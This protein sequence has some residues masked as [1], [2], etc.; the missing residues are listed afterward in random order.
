MHSEQARGQNAGVAVPLVKVG[1]ACLIKSL[2]GYGCAGLM[3]PTGKRER[4]ALLEAALEAGIRHF[5]VAR[6]YGHGGAEG[7]LG[8]FLHETGLRDSVTITTKFGMEPS[9]LAQT[10]GGKSLMNFARRVATLSPGLRSVLSGI[11]QRGVRANSFNAASA[12]GS[13]DAS[14]KELSTDHVDI[15][16]LHEASADSTEAEG[17]LEFL[18]NF[19]QEGKIRAFGLGTDIHTTLEII[20][21]APAFARVVQIPNGIGH[22]NL[23]NLPPDPHRLT[24]TH[25]ALRSVPILEAALTKRPLSPD[26]V[27]T[28]QRYGSPLG[29]ELAGMLLGL[30]I[31]ENPK[32]VTLFSSL[33]PKRI[34][35]NVA[36]ALKYSGWEA[37]EWSTFKQMMD[38]IFRTA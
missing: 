24:L 1:S 20:K 17:L 37:P 33:R 13:L 29:Q 35:E 25:G 5:D 16:L 30:S 38:R 28:W 3:R 4:F 12:R 11:A 23:P 6:Y 34:R 19:K 26:I 27:E 7:V 14:L 10:V 36:A 18:E 22:W 2:V 32:G 31:H 9:P 21:Q 15:F 8:K